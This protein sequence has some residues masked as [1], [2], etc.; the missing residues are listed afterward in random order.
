MG[1]G[2]TIVLGAGIVGLS[3]AY[4]LARRGERV[5][6]VERDRIGEG[7]SSGNAGIIAPG[8]PPLPRPGLPG[9]ALKL[10]FNRANPLFIPP[11]PDPG[12]L[13]WLVRFLRACSASN[14]D[15]SL[16][17][18]AGIGLEA[19]ACV[20]EL[21]ERERLDCEYHPTGWLE[22]FRTG[23][24]LAHA[25]ETAEVLRPRG[26]RVDELSGEELRRAEPAYRDGVAGALHFR[27]SA[28]AHPRKFV[29]GLARKVEELGVELHSETEAARIRIEARRFA[30]IELGNGRRLDG[31]R[32]VLAAGAWSAPLARSIGVRLPMQ[33]GKG[34]HMD[35][36]GLALRPGTTSVLAETFVAVTPLGNGLRLAGTVELSGLD[37][38]VSRVRL[39]RL[40][41]G[42]RDYLSGI[43]GATVEA[44]W[45]GL[46]PM[47]ADG[48]PAIGWAPGVDGVFVATGHAMMGF[49]L[50][51]LTGRL[52]AE[53]LLD[54]RAS[55][56][57]EPFRV[58]RF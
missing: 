15:R 24:A 37:T 18:L 56:D 48:L 34:Y 13:A 9:Q 57:L 21:I 14:Y 3:A 19:G 33:A 26:Y 4:F 8:H 36:T 52:A 25:R 43:D 45:C 31:S 46:R 7:A 30:A 11:R 17:V 5:S 54:G 20:R 35:L 12:L 47:T 39:E 49:L 10:L 58:D 53:V 38:K 44:T 42:A 2:R 1:E 29:R 6:V 22:V 32:L 40:R 23:E 41:A 50:G 51:P 28:F 27:D 55:L 16:A